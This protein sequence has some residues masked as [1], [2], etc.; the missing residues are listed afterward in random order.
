[1]EMAETSISAVCAVENTAK[2][3]E[4]TER[5]YQ[6]AELSGHL[7]AWQKNVENWTGGRTECAIQEFVYDHA[8]DDPAIFTYGSVLRGKNEKKKVDGASLSIGK[9]AW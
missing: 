7:P 9:A 8:Q 4:W 1:M 5:C 3:A 2:A 6:L